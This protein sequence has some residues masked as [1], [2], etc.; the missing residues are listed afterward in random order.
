MKIPLSRPGGR[1]VSSRMGKIATVHRVIYQFHKL[2]VR[3]LGIRKILESLTHQIALCSGSI[4]A[5]SSTGESDGLR[6]RRLRVRAA[7]GAPPLKRW[8]SQVKLRIF[9]HFPIILIRTYKDHSG[10]D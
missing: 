4:R 6:S 1:L 10:D 2:E 3:R 9:D 7:P 8:L 5:R